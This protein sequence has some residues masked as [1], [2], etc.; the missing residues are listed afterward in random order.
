MSN[1]TVCAGLQ[2]ELHR[3]EC[4]IAKPKSWAHYSREPPLHRQM[5]S[6]FPKTELDLGEQQ[7]LGSST[8]LHF[9][10]KCYLNSSEG[11]ST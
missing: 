8:T 7:C 4:H 6:P 2:H 9:P 11:A 10:G 3:P 5:H 1:L